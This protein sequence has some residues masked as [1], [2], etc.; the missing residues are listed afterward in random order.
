MINIERPNQE[1][2]KKITADLLATKVLNNTNFTYLA[3]RKKS[4]KKRKEKERQLEKK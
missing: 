3:T 4:Q 1:N 2:R